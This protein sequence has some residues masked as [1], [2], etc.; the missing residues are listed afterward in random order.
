[1]PIDDHDIGGA[2]REL[3]VK[4][5]T[6]EDIKVAAEKVLYKGFQ[7]GG[8]EPDEETMENYASMTRALLIA[9]SRIKMET[10]YDL[11]HLEF[12]F[13]KLPVRSPWTTIGFKVAVP[14]SEPEWFM[15]EDEGLSYDCN[16]ATEDGN[17]L[18]NPNKVIAEDLA[19]VLYNGF[20]ADR[21]FIRINGITDGDTN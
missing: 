19:T 3:G 18:E 10:G 9:Q 17:G 4:P 13:V 6:E 16:K 2:Q 7:E 20:M 21:E 11:S 1:M 8:I 12:E 15:F 5:I 14:G